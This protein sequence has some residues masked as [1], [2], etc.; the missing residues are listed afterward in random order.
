MQFSSNCNFRGWRTWEML[1][2]QMERF[3]L[4]QSISSEVTVVLV[5]VVSWY[6][7]VE[8]ADCCLCVC[9]CRMLRIDF[10][11]FDPELR[12]QRATV[13]TGWEASAFME[14]LLIGKKCLFCCKHQSCG[15][16]D[17]YQTNVWTSFC[18]RVVSVCIG[19]M[20]NSVAPLIFLSSY[21]SVALI[22]WY[23]TLFFV[24]WETEFDIFPPLKKMKMEL[25]QH[26][27]DSL[28]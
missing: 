27:T 4:I 25:L 8:T 22:G 13:N 12:V 15:W 16:A 23:E 24:Y 3:S 10:S 7:S 11:V 20:T 18:L 26:G 17:G 2:K 19:V 28:P 14:L 5:L 1:L 6:K 9:V 21:S